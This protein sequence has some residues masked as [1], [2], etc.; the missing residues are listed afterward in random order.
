MRYNINLLEAQ[1]QLE[2]AI[3]LTTTK[4]TAI[5]AKK[6]RDLIKN[7]QKISDSKLSAYLIDTAYSLMY[8]QFKK[9]V[10]HLDKSTQ[11]SMIY[12]A[13]DKTKDIL[14]LIKPKSKVNEMAELEYSQDKGINFIGGS[15]FENKFIKSIGDAFDYSKELRRLFDI[16]AKPYDIQLEKIEGNLQIT[17]NPEHG[18]KKKVG[19][20]PWS[21]VGKYLN[22]PKGMADFL[23]MNYR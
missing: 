21:Y 17:L 5:M 4:M 7:S 3:N 15:D 1:K 13:V 14:D 6:A 11:Q 9:E 16:E 19:L 12:N 23:L 10:G 22:N 20:F 2:E 18:Q 8:N